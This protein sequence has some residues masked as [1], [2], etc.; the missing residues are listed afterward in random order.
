MSDKI[1]LARRV[2]ELRI[3]VNCWRQE[4]L[5][6]GFVPTM[7]ALHKGHLALITRARMHADKV[8]ASVFV[9]PTQFG[10]GEDYATYPRNEAQ[11]TALL[12]AAGCHL[13]YLPAPDDIYPP[14][15]AT[16]V[17]VSGLTE[18]MCGATRPGHFDGVATIVTK[19]FHQCQPHIAVFGD[20]DYQQLLVIRRLVADLDM[21][22]EIL[23]QP[24]VR[25]SDGLALSSRN[26]Y[27]SPQERNI[28]PR[29][30]ATLQEMA[31]SLAAGKTVGETLDEGTQALTGLG[32]R[33]DYL[34][35]RDAQTL[36]PAPTT[37]PLASPESHRIFT[38]AWLGQTRLIDNVAIS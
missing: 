25:E 5:R 36:A 37:K 30:Y 2:G 3:R 10:P 21:D 22:I 11:D 6:V 27:L 28:A 14:G 31:H 1:L 18:V 35:I 8:V 19:L 12:A 9:N 15:F 7:G 26:A 23:G 13:A 33:I 16:R 20:K 38:A 17:R 34:D 32:F 29:L 24:T 4:G